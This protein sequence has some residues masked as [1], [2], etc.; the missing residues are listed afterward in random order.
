M[1]LGE[2]GLLALKYCFTFCVQKGTSGSWKAP[3][4][5][6]CEPSISVASMFLITSSFLGQGTAAVGEMHRKKLWMNREDGEERQAQ[7]LPSP[8]LA[9]LLQ[10]HPCWNRR[11]AVPSP[12]GACCFGNAGL[13]LVGKGPCFCL[14]GLE[15][16]FLVPRR[17][18]GLL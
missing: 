12:T 17:S 2:S 18:A 3:L 9:A 4:M 8:E 13:V 1:D 15:I 16:I 7:R 14:H 11:E 6:C 5:N 10:S